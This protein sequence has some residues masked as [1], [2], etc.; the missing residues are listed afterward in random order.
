MTQQEL[1]ALLGRPLTPI[2]VTN[3]GLYLEIALESLEDALCI[4]IE[5]TSS[6]SETAYARTFEPRS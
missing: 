2:E 3:L 6:A 4:E 1:E 5:D